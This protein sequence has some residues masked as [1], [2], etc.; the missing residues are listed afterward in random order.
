MKAY[1]IV[2]RFGREFYSKAILPTKGWEGQFLQK[3]L[4]TL[5]ALTGSGAVIID[6][7]QFQLED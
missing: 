2:Y 1:Q 7:Y 3:V 5:E 6:V 4:N